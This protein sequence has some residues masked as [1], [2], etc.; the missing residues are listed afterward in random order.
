MTLKWPLRLP[1]ISEQVQQR[2]EPGPFLNTFII[3]HNKQKKFFKCIFIIVIMK[4]E[5]KIKYP[6][7]LFPFKA[8]PT[9]AIDLPP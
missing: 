6:S 7:I 2:S 9:G 1:G 8:Y 5:K 4:A 3:N